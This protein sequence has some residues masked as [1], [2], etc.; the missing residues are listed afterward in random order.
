MELEKKK[1]NGRRDVKEEKKLIEGQNALKLIYEVERCCEKR[2]MNAKR[3]RN[4]ER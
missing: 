1:K 4:K 2:Q 3:K